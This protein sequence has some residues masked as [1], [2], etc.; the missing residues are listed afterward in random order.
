MKLTDSKK[1]KFTSQFYHGSTDKNFT[2]GRG[3]HI[4]TYKA[5]FEALSARIGYPADGIWD[6]SVE[7]QEKLIAGKRTLQKLEKEQNIYTQSGFNAGNDVPYEDY[8]VTERKERRAT[9]SNGEPVP[10]DCRPIIFPVKIV[11]PM[12][13]TQSNPHT[14][15]VANRMMIRNLNLGNAK[16]G[17]FYLNIGE[18][19]GSISA[20]VPN[21]NF[22]VPMDVDQ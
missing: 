8:Y 12:S 10:F 19:V 13:N 15:E 17:Y 7:Y 6:G 1:K 5:C 22:L 16:R 21:G 3:I 9:Y 11:G 14:D 20:V 18:D 2:G 4:G